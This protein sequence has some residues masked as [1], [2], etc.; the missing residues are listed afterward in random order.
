[1]CQ[2][3]TVADAAAVNPNDIKMLLANGLSTFS[4]TGNPVFNNSPQS[5]LENPPDF[6]ILC[7][8][9]SDNFTLAG[10]P[11]AKALRN[12]ENCALVNNSL[13]RK[14]FSSFDSSTTFNE[15]FKVTSVPFF[16]SRI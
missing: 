7:N 6:P 8:W 13:F 1:M 9:V 11:F 3:Q 16:D 10:E 2:I 14:L 5:V 15:I 4:I 12:Y